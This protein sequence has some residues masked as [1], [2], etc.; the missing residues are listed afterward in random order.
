MI[1]DAVNKLD[2]SHDGVNMEDMNK[3][4]KVALIINAEQ[5]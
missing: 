5:P 3:M 2:P 1:Y 4:M